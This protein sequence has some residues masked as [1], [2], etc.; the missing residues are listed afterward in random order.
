MLCGVVTEDRKSHTIVA[1]EIFL[2]TTVN[3]AWI[4]LMSVCRWCGLLSLQTLPKSAQFSTDEANVCILWYMMSGFY[5]EM[6]QNVALLIN[7]L[8]LVKL[9]WYYGTNCSSH[10]LGVRSMACTNGVGECV[11]KG[12]GMGGIEMH[13]DECATISW[14]ENMLWRG[15]QLWGNPL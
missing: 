11:W 1:K 13:P 15:N 14:L 10:H 9:H 3:V 5:G 4:L 12:W 8:H 2:F 7:V 6:Y